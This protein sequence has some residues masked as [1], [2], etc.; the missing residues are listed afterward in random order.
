MHGQERHYKTGLGLPLNEGSVQVRGGRAVLH[1]SVTHSFVTSWNRAKR[2]RS[3]RL[4]QT[5]AEECW[6][7]G[8]PGLSQEDRRKALD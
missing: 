1:E 6:E 3:R 7:G 4:W 5:C 2:D 8:D